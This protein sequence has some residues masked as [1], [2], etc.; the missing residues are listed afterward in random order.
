MDGGM[1][2]TSLLE[3]SQTQSREL[4][5]SQEFTQ[6]DS[7]RRKWA[8]SGTSTDI[9]NNWCWEFTSI[10]QQVHIGARP[11]FSV[12][13]VPVSSSYNFIKNHSFPLWCEPL[14]CTVLKCAK[15]EGNLG[16]WLVCL[17]SL[18]CPK[19]LE[20]VEGI[21]GYVSR[22]SRWIY[23]LTLDQ[24]YMCQSLLNLDKSHDSM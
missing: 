19:L 9:F 15:H 21:E 1:G 14:T 23:G 18:G 8:Y 4:I 12:K 5:L 6:G 2:V 10:Y 22:W 7:R 20:Q 13:L 16:R 3:E 11:A 24:K 17:V